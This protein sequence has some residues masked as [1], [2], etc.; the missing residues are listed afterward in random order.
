MSSGGITKGS[1]SISS[2]SGTT[3]NAGTSRTTKVTG[4]RAGLST[5]D[6]M[7]DSLVASS[8]NVKEQTELEQVESLLNS[9]HDVN[10]NIIGN[11][12]FCISHVAG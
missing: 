2:R 7:D 1:T 11:I 9:G 6:A 10:I 3:E 12:Y 4:I 8:Q 5:M